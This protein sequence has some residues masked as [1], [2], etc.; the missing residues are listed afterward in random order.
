MIYYRV[1]GKR[2]DYIEITIPDEKYKRIGY[3]LIPGE[4]Y[5]AWEM[6]K[7]GFSEKDIEKYLERVEIEKSKIYWCFGVRREV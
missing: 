2:N 7:L 5:T 1:K 4:L 6:K 3:E